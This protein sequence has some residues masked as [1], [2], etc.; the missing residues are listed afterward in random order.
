M[1]KSTIKNDPFGTVI[2][3][4]DDSE[5]AIQRPRETIRREVAPLPKTAVA[6]RVQSLPVTHQR[7]QKLTVHLDED[8]ANRVKNAAYWNP[9]LTIARI[10]EHGIRNAIEEVERE[11]GG[12]YKQ[13]ESELIGGRP[14]K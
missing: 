11:N 1:N 4:A 2:P 7:K 9:K 5:T 12:R 6:N 3:L 14:M 8:L 13:R 10:A